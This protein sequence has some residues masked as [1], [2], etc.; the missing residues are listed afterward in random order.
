MSAEQFQKA[1]EDVKKLKTRPTDQEMLEFQKAVE[2][3][4]KLKTRPTDQ[5][6]LEVYALYKQATEGDCNTT[7]PGMLDLKGKA[8]WDAWNSKKVLIYRIYVK[9]NDLFA[10]IGMSKDEAKSA[11]VT[12]AKALIETY[13]LS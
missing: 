11:Y 8:K 13:G 6:M 12:R 10:M 4:K 1:V 3:V 2:D 7:R 9:Y 5:E